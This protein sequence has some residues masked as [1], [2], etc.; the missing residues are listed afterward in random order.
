MIYVERV[1]KNNKE[2][3][4]SLCYAVIKTIGSV[5]KTI[6]VALDMDKAKEIVAKLKVE[7]NSPDTKFVIKEIELNR[8]Y[9]NKQD[10][11]TSEEL[12]EDLF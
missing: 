9:K 10:N 8:V 1:D 2:Y 3:V 11:S 12:D 5:S 6:D 7:N 4:A